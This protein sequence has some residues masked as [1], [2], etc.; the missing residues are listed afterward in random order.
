MANMDKSSV[1]IAQN[2]ANNSLLYSSMTPIFGNM[3]FQIMPSLT[4]PVSN[5]YGVIPY[6]SLESIIFTQQQQGQTDPT[7][8]LSGQQQGSQNIQGSLSVQDSFGNARLQMGYQSGG[9]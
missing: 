5:T 4:G 3:N 7:Q 1:N 9:Y 2:V 6:M 8:I